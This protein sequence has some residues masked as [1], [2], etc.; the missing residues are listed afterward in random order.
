ME[1]PSS[2][3]DSF[4]LTDPR[5]STDYI[6]SVSGRFLAGHNVKQFKHNIL[7]FVGKAHKQVGGRR[8]E[9]KEENWSS[10]HVADPGTT[11]KTTNWIPP[12]QTRY[13]N[14]NSQG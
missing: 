9:N 14:K 8:K 6:F 5:F 3:G 13:P 4:G 7:A 11:S 1:V 12:Y 10:F 2:G